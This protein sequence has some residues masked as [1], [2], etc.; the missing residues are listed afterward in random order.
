M[1]IEERF[2]EYNQ[3]AQALQRV[4][5]SGR[6]AGGYARDSY[7]GVDASDID[8]WIPVRYYPELSRRLMLVEALGDA[9]GQYNFHKVGS[10]HA[11]THQEREALENPHFATPSSNY[12][13]MGDNNPTGI[14]E[15]Y[16]AAEEGFINRGGFNKLQV[17]FCNREVNS[18]EDAFHVN[19]C[20]FGS[21]PNRDGSITPQATHIGATDDF[22]GRTLTINSFV[23]QRP[24]KLVQYMNKL[25]GKFQG[26]R[27]NIS[28]PVVDP[29]F[30]EFYTALFEGGVLDAPR[31]I[32]QTETQGTPG[33]AV[34]QS[35]G[36]DFVSTAGA[37]GGRDARSFFNWDNPMPSATQRRVIDEMVAQQAVRAQLG[38]SQRAN[39]VSNAAGVSTGLP[40]ATTLWWGDTR[41]S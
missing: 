32:L 35:Y 3:V 33:D 19:L 2:S 21:V 38:V 36:E 28:V 24:N 1:T 30:H 29:L 15:A 13:G 8:Y 10:P 31:A 6:I 7:M 16:E 40:R 20:K 39:R 22:V 17:I 27:V 5:R 11:T 9:L 41:R 25:K 4:C 26:A 34:R 18:I 23:G 37:I 12:P 14:V